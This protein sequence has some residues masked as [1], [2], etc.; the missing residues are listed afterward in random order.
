MAEPTPETGDTD[1]VL[2][3]NQGGVVADRVALPGEV[4]VAGMFQQSQRRMDETEQARR[5]QMDPLIADARVQNNK[6][7]PPTPRTQSIGKPPQSTFGPDMMG[8]MQSAM[9]LGAIGGAL[10]RKHVTNSLQAFASSI[11]GFKEGNLQQAKLKMDEWK[12]ETDAVIQNNKQMVDQYTAVLKSRQLDLDQKMNEITLIASQWH[13]RAAYDAAAAKNVIE[14]GKYIEQQRWHTEQL[15]LKRDQM[16]Q[17]TEM[18]RQKLGGILTEEDIDRLAKQGMTDESAFKNLGGG[19]VGNTN[20]ELV[21]KRIT[22]LA[23]EQGKTPEQIAQDRAAFV[24]KKAGQSQGQRTIGAREANTAV[25]V[26]E[27]EQ[28]FPM[29]LQALDAVKASD[30]LPYNRAVQTIQRGVGSP[31]LARLVTATEAVLTAYAQT[32]ARSGTSTVHNRERAERQ[33]NEAQSPAV[34]RAVIDQ[35]Q[36]E[37]AAVRKS[38]PAA[39]KMLEGGTPD[40]PAEDPW[41]IRK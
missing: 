30:Y 40:A 7:L 32:M 35:M 1:T 14:L 39:R 17:Q 3:R 19:M 6:P 36:Q 12:A 16:W 10:G 20:K 15:E 41:G 8:F 5:T 2:E 28:T 25:N 18:F 26:A 34:Y 13:D 31:E 9:I 38:F 27:S 33:L 11:E 37:M 29:A 4:D 24:A 22:A 23:Q 21:Q